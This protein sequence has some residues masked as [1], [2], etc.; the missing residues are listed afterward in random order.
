LV[1]E[2]G[3]TAAIQHVLEVSDVRVTGEKL[4]VKSRVLLL[5]SVAQQ[6]ARRL[7]VIKSYVDKVSR[8]EA[9]SFLQYEAESVV[10]KRGKTQFFQSP[11]R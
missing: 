8:D 7:A 1:S 5:S 9:M 3:T 10:L 6:V 4:P 2:D 11:R